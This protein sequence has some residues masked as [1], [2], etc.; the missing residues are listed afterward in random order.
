MLW[1]NLNKVAS[2]LVAKKMYSILLC[3]RNFADVII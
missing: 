1:D 3:S 2:V